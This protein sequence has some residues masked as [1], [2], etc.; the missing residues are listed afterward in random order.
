MD[1]V[2]NRVVTKEFEELGR[3]QKDPLHHL[4]SGL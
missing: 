1:K 3:S 2:K 4:G